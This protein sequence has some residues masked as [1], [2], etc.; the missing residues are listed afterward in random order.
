MC[1]ARQKAAAPLLRS[2]AASAALRERGVSEPGLSRSGRASKGPMEEAMW[3][4][5]AGLSS[6]SPL[7]RWVQ[8]EW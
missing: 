8:A 6:L 2:G 5:W 3:W 1:A 4:A 7:P